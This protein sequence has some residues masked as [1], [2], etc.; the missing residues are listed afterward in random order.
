MGKT[1]KHRTRGTES[2]AASRKRMAR[3]LKLQRQGKIRVGR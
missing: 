1:N 3:L 2:T